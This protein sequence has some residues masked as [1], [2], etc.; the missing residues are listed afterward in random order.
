MLNYNHIS[1]IKLRQAV[2]LEPRMA[3]DTGSDRFGCVHWHIWCQKHCFTCTRNPKKF[4][5]F[6]FPNLSSEN[7]C[8]HK[9]LI[10]RPKRQKICEL[11]A[12]RAMPWALGEP[13]ENR[14]KSS[15]TI[16]KQRSWLRSFPGSNS[17]REVRTLSRENGKVQMGELCVQLSNNIDLTLFCYN[18]SFFINSLRG[19]LLE[20]LVPA[21]EE[22][23]LHPD[24]E[25]TMT[26]TGSWQKR[27]FAFAQP[28]NA[29]FGLR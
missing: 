4:R 28:W 25:N 29:G 3:V 7:Y 22:K 21:C 23:I 18:K 20:S 12:G 14:K 13:K 16:S 8:N 19:V 10:F 26:G 1:C 2:Q 9:K 11:W 24:R 15:K 27:I 17:T 5:V 6:Y